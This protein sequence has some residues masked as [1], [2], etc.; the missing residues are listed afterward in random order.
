MAITK[1]FD[2][3]E[4]G[5]FVKVIEEQFEG[6]QQKSYMIAFGKDPQFVSN[7]KEGNIEK[8]SQL[9]GAEYDIDLNLGII[10]DG[11]TWKKKHTFD[12]LKSNGFDNVKVKQVEA[13]TLKLDI[14]WYENALENN[15]ENQ[16]TAD[17]QEIQVSKIEQEIK[18]IE[19]KYNEGDTIRWPEGNEGVVKASSYEEQ[20]YTVEVTKSPNKESIG[21]NNN[22]SFDVAR[23]QKRAPEKPKSKFEIGDEIS[24]HGSRGMITKIDENEGKYTVVLTHDPLEMNSNGD[25]TIGYESRVGKQSEFPFQHTK[26]YSSKEANQKIRTSYILDRNHVGNDVHVNTDG[27]RFI[28]HR[29]DGRL[30]IENEEAE[31]NQAK[32]AE[33][34]RARDPISLSLCAEKFL[35][36]MIN[37]KNKDEQSLRKFS[38][39]IFEGYDSLTEQQKQQYDNKLVNILDNNIAARLKRYANSSPKPSFSEVIDLAEFINN[40]HHI[41]STKA[42][43]FLLKVQKTANRTSYSVVISRNHSKH[44]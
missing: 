19:I 31:Y 16:S 23:L 34:L 41:K 29:R 26:L 2:L 12:T 5:V 4:Y 38:N 40:E 25:K 27:Q 24:S 36:D 11:T 30:T 28:V 35:G 22:V 10:A 3:S 20:T 44:L 7:Y 33:F 14:E 13:N 15:V 17:A 6:T 1:W 37:G 9:V 18:K 42:T 32:A 8:I 21:T 39:E 43:T